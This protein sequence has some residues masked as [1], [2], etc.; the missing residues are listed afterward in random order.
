MYPEQQLTVPESASG[1]RLD[2]WLADQLPQHSRNIL[3]GWIKEGRIRVGSHA[4]RPNY[5]VQPGEHIIIPAPPP[6]Q[7]SDLVAEAIA[8]DILYEDADLLVVNKQAG[9][10]VHPAPGHGSGTLVNAILH[11]CPDLGGIGGER[12]PGIVHRLDKDTSGVMVVAKNATAL[13]ALQAQFKRRQVAKQYVALVEGSVK[14]EQGQIIAALG[15]HPIDRKRQA[16]IQ[17]HA[18]SAQSVT[19]REA[20]T[21]YQVIARYTV[22]VR[23]DQSY[24]H[25]SLIHA[26]PLTGR[27]HQI[28]VHLAWSGHPIVGDPL[29]G[30]ARPRLPAP[31]LCL[32][33]QELRLR[34][35][36]T[37]EETAFH[38]PLPTDLVDFFTAIAAASR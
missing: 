5:R 30:L 26:H 35:P 9:L 28:R 17:S 31:R 3:Q 29:Y 24:G 22:P 4:V 21:D 14:D 11:H 23:G 20:I 27:T 25:F 33:A 16:V 19:A 2:R 6:V 13:A 18:G 34:L 7:P 10:V 8:L 1:Q 32:H 38:A 12:R 15:R 37:G 36:S